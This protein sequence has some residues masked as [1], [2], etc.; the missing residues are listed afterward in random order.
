[1]ASNSA[2]FR[3]IGKNGRR[4]ARHPPPPR[5]HRSN[6]RHPS[7]IGSNGAWRM[8]DLGRRG[9]E[10]WIEVSWAKCADAG[11][12]KTFT[13]VETRYGSP[14]FTVDV[15]SFSSFSVGRSAG[16]SSNVK[17]IY[18][19]VGQLPSRGPGFLTLPSS[20]NLKVNSQPRS[21]RGWSEE[22]AKFTVEKKR[23]RRETSTTNSTAACRYRVRVAGLSII[24]S[25]MRL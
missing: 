19:E 23:F 22:S 8:E 16:L 4:G 14:S 17:R 7:L 5:K 13:G 10:V 20:G 9:N 21:P 12:P 25:S 3:G 11:I 15:G 2:M 24:S 6:R 18:R 1:M